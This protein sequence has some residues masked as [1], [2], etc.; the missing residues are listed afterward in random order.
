MGKKTSSGESSTSLTKALGIIEATV[1]QSRP[2]TAAELSTLLGLAKPTAHRL[3]STLREMGFLQ[4][5]PATGGLI[6]GGRLQTLALDVLASSALRGPRHNIL[7]AL[8]EET[9]ES[10]NLGVLAA[11]QVVYQ[12]RV[13]TKWPL[14]LRFDVGSQVPIHCTALGK[15]F[16]SF[17]PERQRTKYLGTLTLTR[18]TENTCTDPSV[19][20]ASLEQIQT[21]GVSFD[22]G[23]FISGVICMAVPIHIPNR[24]GGVVVGIAISAPEAR[25]TLDQMRLHIPALRDAAKKLSLTF[26]DPD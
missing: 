11:G 14:G 19:L 12:D 23:E 20:E 13:E 16:L 22:N 26:E 18:Y 8:A 2:P 1:Q 3:S 9:G 21:E 4:R 15:L 24:N 5:D 10:C 17:M 25:L 6:P 7:S